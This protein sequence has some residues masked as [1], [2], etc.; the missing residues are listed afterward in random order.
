MQLESAESLIEM[1]RSSGLYEAEPF[2][3]LEA[4]LRAAGSD[5]QEL[6]R[7][8]I[9]R[10]RITAYQLRRVVNGR[11]SELFIGP[12]VVLDKLGEGGMGRVYR[13]RHVRQDRQIALKVVRE[14][15]LS[16]PTARGRYEREVQAALALKHPNIVAVSS[17]GSTDGQYYLE[18][19]F[20]DGLDLTRIVQKFG[21][22]QIAESCEYA[23]QAALGLHH[24][25]EQGF[26]HR[27]IK[28]SNIL[29]SGERHRPGATEPAFVK[30]LDMGLVRSILDDDLEVGLTRDGTVVGTPDYMAPEQAKNSRIVDRRA[31]LYSLGAT[32]Y[33]MLTAKPPFPDGTA[34]DKIIRHVDQAPPLLSSLRDDVPEELVRIVDRLMA[35]SPAQRFAT[36]ADLAEA[37]EPLAKLGRKLAPKPVVPASDATPETLIAEATI[38]VPVKASTSSAFHFVERERPIPAPPVSRAWLVIGLTFVSAIGIGLLILV[39]LVAFNRR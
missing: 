26:V 6:I 38:D 4:E 2:A 36:A 28:P 30:I 3:K 35:K 1:L 18:M 32:I 27:D 22:L 33:F 24:A 29:V 13:A 10:G 17:A 25:H 34:L 16:K 20:V 23:R 8:L 9:D 37:L 15:I 7:H 14:Q 21:P 5:P 19:E 12:Y 11:A 31:D 39:L